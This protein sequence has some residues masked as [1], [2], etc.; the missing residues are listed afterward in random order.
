M[1]MSPGH[2]LEYRKFLFARSSSSEDY[3]RLCSLDVLGLE[4]RSEQNPVHQEFKDQLERSPEGWYQ[5]GLIW[6]AGISDLPSNE[7]GSKAR[8]KKLVQRLEKQPELYDKYE[9]IIKEQE[10]EGIIERAPEKS[11]AKEFYLP[12][13]AVVKQSAES[14]KIRIVFDASAKAD[15]KS[16]SLNDCLETGPSL[17][18][19]IWNILVRNR[20]QAVMLSGDLK[21][22]FLQIRI[23][24]QDRDVL[25]L[26]WPKD[27]DLQ[28]LEIYRFTRAIWG[29][30]QSPFQ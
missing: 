10:K 8:L 28:K 21:Q 15:D 19:L 26:H 9:E 24:E 29:L 5:T 25:R 12:H 14:S 7:S 13:R 1:M 3:E 17:Q 27:R 2:E 6:K 11:T 20:M 4:S 23:R 16:P 18:N 22:A 30:N